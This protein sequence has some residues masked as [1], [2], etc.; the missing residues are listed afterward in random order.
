[1]SKAILVVDDNAS[2]RSA[3]CN[4]FMSV[5]DFEVCG[6]A[7]NGREAI[8]KAQQLRPDLILM[9]LSMPIMNGI[10]A[11]RVLKNLMPSVPIILF[12]GYSDV[13]S[14]K[15]ARSAGISLVVS[16]SEHFSVLLDNARR[17]SGQIAA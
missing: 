5:T 9:D 4:L 8:E 15:E 3:V 7:E 16:K 2:I 6:E 13:L 12:S 14:E 1:V 10:A 17:L 11:A